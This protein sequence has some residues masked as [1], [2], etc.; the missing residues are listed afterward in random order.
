MTPEP[1]KGKIQ[2][3]TNDYC[4]DCKPEEILFPEDVKSAVEGCL[5]EID[6]SIR[7]L[8]QNQLIEIK[9]IFKKWFHDVM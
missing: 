6:V 3:Q 8:K 2:K 4:L 1:L 9:K 7:G 5:E